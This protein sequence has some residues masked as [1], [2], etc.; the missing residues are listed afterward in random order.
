MLCYYYSDVRVLA[1]N[2]YD[3]CVKVSEV[4]ESDGDERMVGESFEGYRTG[5]G[6]FGGCCG[7]RAGG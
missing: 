2:S 3:G 6:A 7:G 4:V 1:V 5:E